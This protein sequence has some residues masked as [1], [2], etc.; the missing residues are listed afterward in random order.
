MK[1]RLLIAALVAA[2][3][4]AATGGVLY[5]AYPVQVS[6]FVATVHNL[7]RSWSAPKGTTTTELNPAYKGAATPR[8]PSRKATGA[9]GDWPS[10]NRTLTSERFAPLAE[11]NRDTVGKLK[12]LCT[13][14]TKQYSSF[15]SGLIKVN[16]ALIG[17]TISDIFS[18]DPAT[19]AENWRTHEEGPPAFLS[20]MRGAAYFDG[21]LF[22]GSQDGRVLAYDFKTGKRIWQTT[23]ADVTRG[24]FVPASP[25]AWNGLV[26][27]ANAGGDAKGAKGHMYALDAKTGAIIWQFFLVPKIE[28]DQIRGP[29]GASP[30][31]TS[32]WNNAPG[33]PISGG[34]SWSSYTL[35]PETGELFVPVGNPGPAYASG[36]REGEN[37]FTGS[38]VALDAMTGAY[39]RH[40]KLVHRDWHDWDVASTPSLFET[41]G[42]KKLLASTP[43]DGHL[44]GIDLADNK[45]VFRVPVTKIENVDAPFSPNT[46]VRFCPGATGGAEWSGPAYDPQTNLILAGQTEWCTTVKLQTEQQLRDVHTG[47]VWFGMA[48][49]NPFQ[50]LGRQDDGTSSWAGWVYAVD[51]DS[52]DWKWRLKSNYPIVG[53]VTPTAGGLAF[54]GDVG[55]N[56]YALDAATGEKLWGQKIGGAI[57][58]GVIAYEAGGREKIAVTTGLTGVSWPTEHVTGQI[59]V[60]GI[61]G[62]PATP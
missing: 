16:G 7:L 31:D 38:I 56:F 14:D 8:S 48:T 4:V 59:V 62:A 39:K 50:I 54:F 47:G 24:E 28:G 35:D 29:Q 25:I 22:R 23:I 20:A 18:I 45:I 52:G 1:T 42:G 5:R 32:T 15:E 51:A 46:E 27:I 44:Y 9:D 11:I 10:Y 49:R 55:G 43:K 6:I 19:C 17:T 3:L 21:M 30:L 60:L 61:D 37:L 41:A 12:V 53:A 33:I 34:G 58:G 26:F 2:A 36:V 13:Y 40:F 57:G